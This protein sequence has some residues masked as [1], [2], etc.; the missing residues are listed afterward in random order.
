MAK[1]SSVKKPAIKPADFVHLHLHSHYSLLDGL[2]KVP[3]LLDRVKELGMT[4]AA[5]TDHG[6][7]SG[8]IEFYK[9]CRDRDLRPIIGIEA[10]LARRGR[11]DKDAEADRRF[12]HLIILA[13]NNEGYQNLM[14]LSTASYLE[15]FYYKPRIDKELLVKHGAGLIILS[16]CMGGEIGEFIQADNYEKAKEVALWYKEHFG[17]RFY[18]EIQ[19]HG[20]TNPVQ[21]R[22]NEAVLRLAEE[23][24]IEPV[25]TSDSH[26]L[27]REDQEAHEV[28]LSIQTKRFFDDEQRMSLKEYDLS[29]GRSGRDY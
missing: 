3:A 11:A 4:A 7:L 17:D 1:Q 18:L 14:K 19:D 20:Q 8:A 9:G 22:I 12:T 15:G 27:K 24:A 23:L 5:L 29:L 21:G 13:Q 10:Y 16:G 25:L 26:Y 2:S 28:L 6:T